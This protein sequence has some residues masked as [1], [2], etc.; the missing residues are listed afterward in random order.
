[1]G[2]MRVSQH[3]TYLGR[4]ARMKFPLALPLFPATRRWAHA[5]HA[6]QSYSGCHTNIA[7]QLKP[8]SSNQD[9][10]GSDSIHDRSAVLTVHL[11]CSIHTRSAIYTL[12]LSHSIA[13]REH[14][15]Y[16]YP[17]EFI[18]TSA[19]CNLIPSPS[20]TGLPTLH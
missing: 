12:V 8:R 9:L 1:M 7:H 14:V 13:S 16:V 20:H 10:S 15:R 17:I 11:T 2:Q 6:L 18:F 4:A 3:G 19:T 5:L